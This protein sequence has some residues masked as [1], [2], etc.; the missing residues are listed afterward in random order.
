MPPGTPT[1]GLRIKEPP[2]RRRQEPPPGA[3]PRG[4]RRLPQPHPLHPLQLLLLLLRERTTE[5]SPHPARAGRPAFDKPPAFRLNRRCRTRA[6]SLRRKEPRSPTRSPPDDPATR[7]PHLV[8]H[9]PTPSSW[10]GPP[11]TETRTKILVPHDGKLLFADVEQTAAREGTVCSPGR[12]CFAAGR[13]DDS[14]QE[15]SA[16][17]RG[18]RALRRW[19]RRPLPSSKLGVGSGAPAAA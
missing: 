1:V 11:P 17:A 8:P 3:I 2:L 19:W 15:G 18:L 13:G 6:G 16:A 14:L 5:T 12:D 4:R 9:R 7:R 10:K